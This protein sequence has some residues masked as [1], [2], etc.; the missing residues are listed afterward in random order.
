MTD[1]KN[2]SKDFN[3]FCS[4]IVESSHVAI[5]TD[6]VEFSVATVHETNNVSLLEISHIDTSKTSD[7]DKVFVKQGDWIL[8]LNRDGTNSNNSHRESVDTKNSDCFYKIDVPATQCAVLTELQQYKSSKEVNVNMQTNELN[9]CVIEF[10]IDGNNKKH[11]GSLQN[12]F[13]SQC[14]TDQNNIVA[15]VHVDSNLFRCYRDSRTVDLE[16]MISKN[17]CE[18]YH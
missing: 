18:F 12:I 6:L 1:Y 7:D 16:T 14:D 4:K 9:Q 15:R 11:K 13:A 17:T 10:T 2:L 5:D 8:K 3:S